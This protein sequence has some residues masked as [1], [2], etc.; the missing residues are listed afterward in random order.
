MTTTYK[1]LAAWN[2]IGTIGT[3]DT[4]YYSVPSATSS[5]VSTI[6]V[7]NQAATTATYRIATSTTTAYT[8]GIYV[9]YGA[10]I[11]AN[12]TIFITVGMTLDA[13]NKYLLASGSATT[14]SFTVFGS[15]IT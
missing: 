10:T 2:S 8:G 11:A 15:E 9:V 12:D 5:V 13:V 7:C 3:A 6:A 4:T 14:V 1:R